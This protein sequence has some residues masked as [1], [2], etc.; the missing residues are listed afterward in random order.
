VFIC[1]IPLLYSITYTVNNTMINHTVANQNDIYIWGDSQMFQ[2]LNLELLKTNK[3]VY[4]A[5]KHGAGVYDFLTFT[6]NTPPNSNVLLSLSTP[7]QI[8]NKEHDRSISYISLKSIYTLFQNNY[9]LKE[10][11]LIIK[12]N[13][14]PSKIFSESNYLY[15][16]NENIKL[17]KG[18]ISSFTKRFSSTPI[19][20]TDKQK[21][22]NKGLNQLVQKNVS[23]TFI[24]LPLHPIL[25]K[26][27]DLFPMTEEINKFENSI[28]DKLK[29]TKRD[30]IY[31]N[32]NLEMMNDLTHLNE[33]GATAVTKE[34]IE[35]LKEKNK[36]NMVTVKW[37]D[38]IINP[39][40]LE[41]YNN[42]LTK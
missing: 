6:E 13:L 37:R 1:I 5:S 42:S 28:I 25:N 17:R 10:I 41:L 7:I 31:L 38:S 8:R 21:I 23:I 39:Y 33:R 24:N 29:I 22:L 2:G 19:Y 32:K 18:R 20:L 16:N 27:M 9:T 26:V 14:K 34:L 4:F 40:A 11:Y 3:N 15:E 35:I 30:S 12:K 36:Y